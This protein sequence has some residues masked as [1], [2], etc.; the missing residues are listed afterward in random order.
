MY[1]HILQ[2]DAFTGK[3]LGVGTGVKDALKPHVLR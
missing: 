1:L 2:S 3:A